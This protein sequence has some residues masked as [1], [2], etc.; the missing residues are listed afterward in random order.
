MKMVLPSVYK[1]SSDEEFDDLENKVIEAS[2][3]I[4]ETH[5]L[6]QD[7]LPPSRERSLTLT[8][9]EEAQHWIATIQAAD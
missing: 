9:L 6:I 2:K 3:A 8:K 7:T 5:D 1:N 4:A